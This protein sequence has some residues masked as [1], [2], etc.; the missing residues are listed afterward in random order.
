MVS[1]P[2]AQAQGHG[3]GACRLSLLHSSV[4]RLLTCL[5]QKSPSTWGGP[6]TE[7]TRSHGPSSPPKPPCQQVRPHARQAGLPTA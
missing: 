7:L 2:P 6:K 3:A 4:E 1:P 5:L